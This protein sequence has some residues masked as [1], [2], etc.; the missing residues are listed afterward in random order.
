MDIK[1]FKDLVFARAK[2]AGFTEYEI[3]FSKSETFSVKVRKGN[4]EEYK[5]AAPSG[6]SFRGTYEDKTGYSFTERIDETVVDFLIDN[7]KENAMVKEEEAEPLFKGSESY[8]EVKT[9]SEDLND[10]SAADKIALAIE[11]EKLTYA[12]DSRVESVDAC[13]V[14]SGTTEK[15]IANSHGLDLHHISGSGASYAGAKVVEN[16]SIKVDFGVWA[17]RDF[18]TIDPIKISKEAVSKAV[19]KLGAKSVPSGDYDIVL[20]NEASKDIFSAVVGNFYAENAQKGLSLLK[21]KVGE[22]I[23]TSKLTI[24]DNISHPLSLHA[25]PFDSEGVAVCD[26]TVIEDGVLKTFLYNQKAAKKENRESTG[27]GFKSSYKGSVGTSVNNFFIEPG[28]ITFDGMLEKIDKGIVITGLSGIHS[29]INAV[30]GDFSL[31]A[32]GF[33]IEG[34]KQTRP[35]EQITIAGNFYN[36]LKDIDI[37]ADDLYFEPFSSMGSPSMLVKNIKVSG[38]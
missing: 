8:P 23:A 30:S 18:S 25:V 1:D 2:E 12:E 10:L 29:G 9:L 22:Q 21:G 3:Y 7:A 13:A 5:N 27:N 26:K 4:I 28:D 38:E 32:D 24:R 37:I 19:S 20:K 36:L 6:L 34:G 17:A 15:Y 33:L 31:E 35:V 16:G 14:L 11:I